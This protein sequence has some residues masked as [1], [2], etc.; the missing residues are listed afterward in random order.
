[1]FDHVAD[2]FRPIF[3]AKFID[4][5]EKQ[6][7]AFFDVI[8]TFLGYVRLHHKIHRIICKRIKCTKTFKRNEIYS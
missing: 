3:F 5:E 2:I 8:K 6:H 4:K 7:G 1:M